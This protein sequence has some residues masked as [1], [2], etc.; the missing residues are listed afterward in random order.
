L[1]HR[2][3]P[4][5][6]ARDNPTGLT[7]A[8]YNVHQWRGTDG[9]IDPERTFEAI[10]RLEADVVALQEVSCPLENGCSL[11]PADIG[12]ALDCQ[13]IL[14]PT[15]QKQ[16]A[17]FGNLLLTR[18]PVLEINQ[19]NISH[20]GR[21]PRGV[22]LARLEHKNKAIRVAAT[23][24]GLSAGERRKQV[25][26]LLNALKGLG[27]GPVIILGDLNEWNP[28]G[29]VN[30]RLR[31]FFGR[32]SAPATFPARRPL[33]ALVRVLIKPYSKQ[34]KV[35]VPKAKIYRTASDHRPVVAKFMP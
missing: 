30:R 14:G 1:Q 15:F 32:Q 19:L 10:R 16:N 5:P 27:K 3:M 20:F 29:Y 31:N 34:T 33:V 8:S 2:P 35:V 17:D 23:H 9:L 24:L 28:A 4:S 11:A 26:L 13:A 18:L 7:L 25:D 22:I 21:E 6:S 12:K